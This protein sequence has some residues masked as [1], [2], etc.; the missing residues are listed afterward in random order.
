MVLGL[1]LTM[2][3]PAAA[4]ETTTTMDPAGEAVRSAVLNDEGVMA[5]GMVVAFSVGALAG[6]AM[7]G[8]P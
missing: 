7:W 4:E 3:A 6:Q 5:L 1:M 2:A 8:R